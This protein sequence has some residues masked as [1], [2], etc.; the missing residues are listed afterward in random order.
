MRRSRF[1]AELGEHFAAGFFENESAP[2]YARHARAL[3]RTLEHLPEPPYEGGR[4]YP[5]GKLDFWNPE[6]R[7]AIAFYYNMVSMNGNALREKVKAASGEDPF[8][9]S[10]AEE[11][12][13]EL[14]FT[15]QNGIPPQYGIGGRG[16]T[17]S[18][19]NYS[20]ILKEG[21]TGYRARILK[22]KEENP[23]FYGPLLEVLD[24]LS[25]CFRRF[26]G[27]IRGKAPAELVSALERV[28]FEPP[29]N[30]YEAFVAVNLL[31]YVD[32]CDSLGRIDRVFQEYVRE[33][34]PEEL[35]ALFEELWRNFDL[36]EGWHVLFDSH[37]AVSRPA[38]AGQR[39]Y[40]RPNSGILVDG[41]TPDS[42]WNAVFDSWGAGNPSPAL[43]SRESYS[44]NIRRKIPGLTK[45]DAENFAF[46]GCT[47]LMIQGRSHSSSID[48]GLNLLSILVETGYDFPD[49][50]AFY[51][52]FLNNILTQA[53]RMILGVKR[54][55]EAAALYRSQ[56]IRTLFTDYCI[57]HACE[58]NAGGARYNTSTIN[59]AG[60]SNTVN[61]LYAL[62]EMYAGRLPRFTGTPSAA[63]RA[64]LQSL[65]KF[66][67]D[68]DRVDRIAKKLIREVFSHV[69][70]FSTK[71]R[72]FLPSVIL[73]ETYA[74]Y[75]RYVPATPDGRA[76]GEPLC[77]SFGAVQGT[78]R[79]GPTALLNSLVKPDQSL[80][81]GTLVLNLRLNRK[82]FADPSAR[83]RLKALF[84]SY[85]R[86]GGLQIQ[87][88]IAD[89]DTLRR[90][91]A[92]PENY[93]S[94]M[95]RIGG[96]SQYFTRLSKELQLELLKREEHEV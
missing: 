82:L 77:D 6:Q 92:H 33:E 61:S 20:R 9:C 17:H 51:G 47:E 84:L 40:R 73:F 26:A 57:D 49:Y 44:R 18:I 43:Y 80:G 65:P 8:R 28:P 62:R 31:W 86:R 89:S 87:P 41:E 79:K 4:L 64:R 39:K 10:M 63:F 91:M 95:I 36:N 42:A 81:L 35:A 85:F 16:W 11:C 59:F 13:R 88:T 53:D 23:P 94:V 55:H 48:A 70:S 74:A 68:D 78:D 69:E 3:V 34:T 2:Y 83:E 96:Y 19:L 93:A 56:L 76:D 25:A 24:A 72:A 60:L 71:E 12:I 67:N 29:R 37:L 30:V 54:N 32:G 46:G 66:G 7:M 22:H 58:F 45:T 90:A 52:A 38:I 50:A 27:G 75:G 14:E 5:S 15:L 21:L 1:L